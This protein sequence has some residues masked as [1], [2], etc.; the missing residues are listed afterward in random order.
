M[1]WIDLWGF[2]LAFK[3]C[4]PARVLWAPLQTSACLQAQVRAEKQPSTI[5]WKVL[6]DPVIEATAQ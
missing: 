6:L 3:F 1:S 5:F 2:F 4:K